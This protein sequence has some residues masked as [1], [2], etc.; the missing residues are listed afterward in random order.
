MGGGRGGPRPA[1]SWRH[2]AREVQRYRASVTY[3]Q[4]L[5]PGDIQ[6]SRKR[7]PSLRCLALYAL[8][9]QQSHST[10]RRSLQPEGCGR[11][12][13]LLDPR[14]DAHRADGWLC[15]WSRCIRRSEL[16]QSCDFGYSLLSCCFAPLLRNVRAWSRNCHLDRTMPPPSVPLCNC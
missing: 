13:V 9:L 7:W 2:S 11:I 1:P 15:P 10:A 8:Q 6:G 14:P 16:V 3:L 5:G 4:G 12:G